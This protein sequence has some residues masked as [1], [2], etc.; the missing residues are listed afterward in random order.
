MPRVVRREKKIAWM[1]STSLGVIIV[2]TAV[3][4]LW[5]K[6]LFD[7]YLLYATIIVVFPPAVLDYMEKRWKKA[8][9]ER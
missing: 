7:D 6:P 8:I 3:L 4:T 9:N 2:A 5:N 1:V